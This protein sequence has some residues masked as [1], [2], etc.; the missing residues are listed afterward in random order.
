MKRGVGD[1]TKKSN[2]SRP[3]LSKLDSE[4]W[5]ERT[6]V[7]RIS[8]KHQSPTPDDVRLLHQTQVMIMCFYA[9]ALLRYR[10]NPSPANP[11]PNKK[12]V[13]GSGMGFVVFVVFDIVV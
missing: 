1:G 9:F 5:Q 8:Y 7:W 3:L 4:S 2:R 10:H 13:L 12:M 6:A 11:E